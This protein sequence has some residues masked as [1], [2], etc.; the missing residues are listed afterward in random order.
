MIIA[1]IAKVIFA[2]T[3]PFLSYF[4]TNRV[5]LIKKKR[6]SLY[7]KKSSKT[8]NLRINLLR[9]PSIRILGIKKGKK[10]NFFP[11]YLQKLDY[12]TGDFITIIFSFEHSSIE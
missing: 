6:S 5:N 11:F 8:L 12:K 9:V 2:I 3:T 7:F 4:I 1:N 10:F